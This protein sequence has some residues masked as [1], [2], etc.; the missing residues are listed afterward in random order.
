VE[1][2]PGRAV[3]IHGSGHSKSL[4][5]R[6]RERP[7]TF[8]LAILAAATVALGAPLVGSAGAQDTSQPATRPRSTP[9]AV[10]AAT[11][12]PSIPGAVEAAA[13]P[14]VPPTGAGAHTP[15][16]CPNSNL[17]PTPSN[18]AAVNVTVVCLIDHARGAA[19]LRPLHPNRR[20]QHVAAHQAL[21]MVLGDYFG[22]DSRSGKTP[23]QRIAATHYTGHTATVSTA[24]NIGWGTGAEAT[25]AD[26]VAAWMESP[27]HRQ[28]IL[29]GAFRD[30]GVGVAAAAP[31]ALAQGQ[32]GATY[33]VEF[34][35]RRQ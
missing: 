5:R 19:H 13:T 7:G 14:S 3:Q 32:S 8:I 18:L 10:Q 34:G 31:A 25:P 12:L 16:P 9:R 29:T 20:L 4:C 26:M 24:Q 33:T 17:R 27:P 1:S 22:D 30:I 23:L 21:E 35:T 6:S 2:R 28:I 11:P 15:A